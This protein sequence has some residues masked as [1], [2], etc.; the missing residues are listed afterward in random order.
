MSILQTV[1]TATRSKHDLMENLIGSDRLSIFSIEDYNL[2]L[3]T[4]YLFHS[5]LEAKVR[6]FL[7]TLDQ[8]KQ[9]EPQEKQLIKLNFKE[10]VKAISLEQELKHILPLSTFEKL[11][12][13]PN[14]IYFLDYYSLL[15]HV[16]VAEG[17]MLGGKMM[18]KVLS[19]NTHINKVT[20]FEFFKN[21]Q[22]KTLELWKDFK[23]LV[24]EGCTSEQQK[25]HFLD[26]A[27]KS[28][29]YFEKAFYQAKN[30][31]QQE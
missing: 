20:R 18:H 24:V 13:L 6:I 26:G 12:S 15:G 21:Y 29:M 11:K 22:H 7:S 27:E 28:Y 1:R 10:R 8:K 14:T 4:N 2:L 5:H 3:S 19:Q 16:Y 25:E 31:L 17:S 9:Q 30:I 23:E